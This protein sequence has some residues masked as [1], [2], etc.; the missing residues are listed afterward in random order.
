MSLT[1]SEELQKQLTIIF[2]YSKDDLQVG[3]IIGVGKLTKEK[4]NELIFEVLRFFNAYNG[5]LRDYAGTEIYAIEFEL[6]NFLEKKDHLKI[7]PKSMVVI[8]GEYKD[9][10]TL[11]LALTQESSL[12]NVHKAR[13]SIDHLG[14]LF[15][16]VD[17][18]VDRPELNMEEK[19]NILSKF[20]GRF[21]RKLQGEILEGKWNKKLVGI[22]QESQDEKTSFQKVST[23]RAGY[24]INW[25]NLNRDINAENPRFKEFSLDLSDGDYFN[26][27]K[28]HITEPSI[29]YIIKHTLKLAAN[30]L[31]IANAGSIDEIHEGVIQVYVNEIRAILRKQGRIMEFEEFISEFEEALKLTHDFFEKYDESIQLYCRSG[32]VSDL[33]GLKET[34]KQNLEQLSPEGE[35][36]VSNTLKTQ[37]KIT[38]QTVFSHKES[39]KA[40]EFKSA[41]DY[42][43]QTVA[44]AHKTISNNFQRFLCYRYLFMQYQKFFRSLIEELSS[45]EK[46]AQTLGMRFLKHISEALKNEIYQYII[47]QVDPLEF[48]RISLNK[49][50]NN[51]VKQVV[52]KFVDEINIRINDL[53]SFA[54]IMLGEHAEKAKVHFEKLKHVESEFNYLSNFVLRYS[55][56]NR[57][58]QGIGR[59]DPLDPKTLS[60]K[61]KN[62]LRKRL[63]GLR[64]V[65][66]DYIL[67]IIDEFGEENQD[68][69][70]QDLMDEK[71]WSKNELMSMFIDYLKEKIIENIDPQHFI[72]VLDWYIAQIQ[73]PTQQALMVLF[74]EQYEYSLS[75]L[76][77]FPTYMKQKMMKKLGEIDFETKPL[78]SLDFLDPP[79]IRINQLEDKDFQKKSKNGNSANEMDF[80]QFLDEY[81]LMYFSKL[82]ARPKKVI[83]RSTDL[84]ER[85]KN[86]FYNIGFKFW[87]N[88][89]K[90]DVQDNWNKHRHAEN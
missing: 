18:V 70:E 45:E 49:Q 64:I 77:D 87:E 54:E 21:S 12:L 57:F 9:C 76:N 50:F 59:E 26:Y 65:W 32:T 40:I 43:T 56:L 90:I 80:F 81:E 61:F 31:R 5:M 17:E 63:G 68:K 33:N 66:K 37:E 85:G 2:G 72:H 58:I 48:D 89:F 29:F 83:L 1:T 27:R 71:V 42:F 30:L 28:R 84:H 52:N 15:F 60:S 35:S 7:L 19:T 10:N 41:M 38:N 51:M 36:T 4:V 34:L 11:L 88:F 62:F 75:I 53:M 13:K 23:I 86:L 47:N 22:D 16:Q 6:K 20:T 46:P 82:I 24:T 39:I 3:E 14:E 8:P 25:Q 73:D 78:K 44:I 74:F 55:S 79:R 67:N 69:F